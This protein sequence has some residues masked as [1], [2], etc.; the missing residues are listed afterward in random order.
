MMNSNSDLLAW[1]QA[2]ADIV[3]SVF[4]VLQGIQFVEAPPLTLLDIFVGIGFVSVTIRFIQRLR[5]PVATNA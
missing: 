3:E 1:V 5:A 4:D 2:F